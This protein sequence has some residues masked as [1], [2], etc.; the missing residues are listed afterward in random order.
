MKPKL[1]TSIAALMVNLL[2][3]AQAFGADIKVIDPWS[4]ALPPTVSAGAAYFEI[5]NQSDRTRTLVDAHSD[6]A[7]ATT[8]CS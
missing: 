1:V 6:I 7:K 4:R 2:I 3:S 8:L 5:T